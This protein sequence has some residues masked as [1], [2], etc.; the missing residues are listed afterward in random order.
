MIQLKILEYKSGTHLLLFD[1][2]NTIVLL[3]PLSEWSSINLNNSIFN[4][5]IGSDVFVV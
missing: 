1:N 4:Q 3:I 2:T 5:S